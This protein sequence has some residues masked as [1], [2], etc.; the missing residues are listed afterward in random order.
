[1]L[2]D[3]REPEEYVAG[4]VPGSINIPQADLASRL[5]ELPRNRPLHVIC[6][7]G[8]R[9]LRAAQFLKQSGFTDVATVD[10]GT[11]AWAGSGR[12]LGT[13]EMPLKLPRV[14]ESLWPHAGAMS[15]FDPVL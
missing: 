15:A 3:V 6:Q 5:D 14:V 11:T 9:S 1:V 2:V 13:G 8:M 12:S 7:H 10:G 4:H